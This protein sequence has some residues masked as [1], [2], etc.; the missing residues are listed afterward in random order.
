MKLWIAVA[1]HNFKLPKIYIEYLS[2]LRV[3]SAN[4]KSAKHV[5]SWFNIFVLQTL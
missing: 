3:K 4:P 2:A 5:D 1:R